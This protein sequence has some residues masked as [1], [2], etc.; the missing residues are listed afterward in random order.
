[1]SYLLNYNNV[2]KNLKCVY[3][4]L[5]S[6]QDT[7]SSW[8]TLSG[9]VI[10]YTP[11][12]GSSNVIYEYTTSLGPKDSDNSAQLKLQWGS[13]ENNVGDLSGVDIYRSYGCNVTNEIASQNEIITATYVLNVN[14]LSW[15]SEKTLLLKFR[16]WN[17]NLSFE[18]RLHETNDAISSYVYNP[19]VICYSI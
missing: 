14:S 10:S 5:S 11:A 2:K 8:N 19:F 18:S 17:G 13:D 6:G 3:T 15:S 9:S 7:G 12:P 1:M 4:E 16:A